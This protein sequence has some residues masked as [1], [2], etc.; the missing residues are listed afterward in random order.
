MTSWLLPANT[1]FYD[2]FGA[3]EQDETYWPM[4]M[5][6]EQGDD[7][8]IY[9]AAPYKQIGFFADIVAVD[10][11]FDLIAKEVAPFIKGEMA[12]GQNKPFMSLKPKRKFPIE[13]HGNLALEQL[14]KNGLNGML[15][16]ARKLDNNPALH[17]YIMD[18]IK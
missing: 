12:D 5:K 7:I 6:A 2:V 9:L 14:K 13:A 15:M 1:K 8:F 10:I 3:F 18:A 17:N 16:G 4:N 11:N